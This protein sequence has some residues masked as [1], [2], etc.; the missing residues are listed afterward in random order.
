[1]DD[2]I[3]WLQNLWVQRMQLALCWSLVLLFAWGATV[4]LSGLSAG[5]R[6]WIWRL[7]YLKLFA[8]LLIPTVWTLPL[9]RPV[10]KQQPATQHVQL[11]PPPL[12]LSESASLNSRDAWWP[13]AGFLLCV[14][15]VGV[16]ALSA[17]YLAGWT[18]VSRLV[19]ATNECSEQALIT[20][21][22]ELRNE[23]SVRAPVRL[24]VSP[25]ANTP[26]VYG[27]LRPTI[28]LPEAF[29]DGCDS[30]EQRAILAHELAHVSRRDL[31]WNLVHIAVNSALFFHPIIWL[32]QREWRLSQELAC[33]E[34]ALTATN[35]SPAN[36]AA[37]LLRLSYPVQTPPMSSVVVGASEFPLLKRRL[38]MLGTRPSNRLNQPLIGSLVLA[39]AAIVLLAPWHPVYAEKESTPLKPVEAPQVYRFEEAARIGK[40]KH[41]GPYYKLSVKGL[42][43]D[44]ADMFMAD[45]IGATF[46]LGVD[47]SLV[48]NA[49]HVF[50]IGNRDGNKVKFTCLWEHRTSKLKSIDGQQLWTSS[51]T[52]FS[53]DLE[54]GSSTTIE[55]VSPTDTKVRKK[56][57]VRVVP[58]NAA[59]K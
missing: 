7:A 5:V 55:L 47:D 16:F 8:V 41:D 48:H 31:L 27:F 29:F 34:L 53:S 49:K 26:C 28:I 19:E 36:Y 22:E 57:T 6:S 59:K 44:E 24:R 58:H 37:L 35:S 3:A 43:H 39:C 10:S 30:S 2:S 38:L 4:G 12:Q 21:L 1:M 17:K 42:V 45:G 18:R 33:D 9:E 11:I 52:A 51:F 56:L 25:H 14:W 50:T 54:L 46:L 40:Q 32:L 20:V 23:M 13:T 15:L